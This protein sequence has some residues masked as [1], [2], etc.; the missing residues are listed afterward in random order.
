MYK[1]NNKA[2]EILN[3]KKNC[4]FSKRFS[5]NAILTVTG[6]HEKL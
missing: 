5:R 6:M 1:S 3:T 4:K 2:K